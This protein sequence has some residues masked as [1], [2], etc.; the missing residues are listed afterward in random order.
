MGDIIQSSSCLQSVGVTLLLFMKRIWSK[1]V[2]VF[3]LILNTKVILKNV[4]LGVYFLRE[5]TSKVCELCPLSWKR[6][7]SNPQ[8]CSMRI[9]SSFTVS[10]WQLMG[11]LK[12]QQAFWPGSD[13]FSDIYDK[14]I[15]LVRMLS[16]R[17]WRRQR[18]FHRQTS[19]EPRP[20]LQ[21][22]LLNLF[23][24]LSC[25]SYNQQAPTF[26]LVSDTTAG[27]DQQ[28][29]QLRAECRH[30]WGGGG[31]QLL[32]THIHTHWQTSTDIDPV[33]APDCKWPIR[34]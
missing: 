10:H 1:T 18:D 7:A 20:P 12:V 22:E 24:G 2:H 3:A 28:I 32:H 4:Y 19:L 23:W 11:V 13:M 8:L 25:Q 5:K 26:I 27:T 31:G 6:P 16:L 14:L 30:T 29:I 17:S 34:V 15:C 9:H 33:Q 21:R